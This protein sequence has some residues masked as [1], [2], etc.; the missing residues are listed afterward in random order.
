LTDI[1]N[2]RDIVVVGQQAWDVDIGSNNINI[3]KEFAKHN[4]VLYVNPPLDTITVLRY[5]NDEKVKKRLNIIAGS[6]K[7]LLKVGDNIWTFY[8]KIKLTSSNWIK[9]S[10]IFDFMNKKNNIK[11]ANEIKRVINELNFQNII[12]F[13]DS[14]MFRSFYLKELLQP[15]ISVYYSR[16]NMI[17]MD[18]FKTHGVRIE[19][20]L[21][22]KSDLAVA[23]STYLSEYC[24]KFNPNSFYVGQGC[25][26]SL[27]NKELIKG[28]PDD[29][30]DI[31]HPRIGYVGALLTLRLDIEIIE[32]IANYNSE[33]QIILVGPEDD[34]FKNS[35]LHNMKNVHFTG[36]KDSAL[37]P[38]YINSF[39]ICINPQLL[40]EVT[41]GNYPRK[42][43]EYLAMEKPVVATKT[44][45][46]SIFSDYTYLANKKED[47]AK[48]IEIAL[49]EDSEIKKSERR[50][51]ASS[52][53]WE[54][55]VKE[56]Y[57]A[58]NYIYK[59]RNGN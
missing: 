42:I 37:L 26:L 47:Y 32:Y 35:K 39:D 58:I 48:L 55:N 53:T 59:Q 13:N 15:D 11:F 17:V 30:K 24:K 36:P 40:N 20:E 4:R 29:V 52:H 28:E 31:S 10:K 16:D 50:A 5:K 51:F 3:A 8:P 2:N 14:D 21:I 18:Y 34:T 33:W 49:K 9:I 38:A 57:K 43:D 45:A 7:D 12:L 46:M 1:I 44:I 19:A 54:N 41:I 6:E 25:D 23:N 27:F 22:R 56:I